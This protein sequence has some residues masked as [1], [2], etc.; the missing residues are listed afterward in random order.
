MHEIEENEKKTSEE[1][2]EVTCELKELKV[3]YDNLD[4]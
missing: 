3:S 4:K 2:V 1:L